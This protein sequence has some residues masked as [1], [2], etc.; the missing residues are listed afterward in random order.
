[1]SV[2]VLAKVAGEGLADFY[3]GQVLQALGRNADAAKAFEQAAKHG[4]DAVQCLLHRAGAVRASGYIDQAEE[5]VELGCVDQGLDC[6]FDGLLE[7]RE[8]MERPDWLAFARYL[9]DEHPLR[10]AVYEDP[11]TRRAF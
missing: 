6:L 3:H 11:M 9:R 4:Y 5:L 7:A 2:V 1:M 8:D 10:N